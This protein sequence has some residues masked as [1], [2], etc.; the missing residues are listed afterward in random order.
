MPLY[1]S[2]MILDLTLIEDKHSTAHYCYL[3]NLL[4]P[5]R[6]H[7]I[8]QFPG[9]PGLAVFALISLPH[10]LINCA[11]CIHTGKAKSSHILLHCH[12]STDQ[13]SIIFAISQVKPS[14]CYQISYGVN[15][16]STKSSNFMQ[17]S[18]AIFSLKSKIFL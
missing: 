15:S 17:Y 4:T 11:V 12:I 13:I 14:Q 8:S 1:M 16:H 9:T 5:T 18:T 6:Y 3:N 7:F 2:S 10:L